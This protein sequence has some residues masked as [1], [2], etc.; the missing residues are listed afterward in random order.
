MVVN[1]HLLS[2][3]SGG[4]LHVIDFLRIFVCT[5]QVRCWLWVCFSKLILPFNIRLTVLQSSE[6]WSTRISAVDC[7]SLL[8]SIFSDD[9]IKMSRISCFGLFSEGDRSLNYT[10]WSFTITLTSK[11]MCYHINYDFCSTSHCFII[12]QFSVPSFS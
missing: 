8:I 7:Y 3:P 11:L 2:S 1:M 5:T 10:D 4:S 6:L 12:L 9:T